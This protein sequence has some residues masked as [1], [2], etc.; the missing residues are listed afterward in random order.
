MARP[1]KVLVTHN[2]ALRAKH[3]AAGVRAIRAA[4]D[5]LVEAD[6]ARGL[7][8]RWLAVDDKRTARSLGAAAVDDP[9]DHA[10]AK[11]FVDAA[12]AKWAPDYVVLLGSPDVIPMQP[13]RNPLW[14]GDPRRGD[15]DPD[16]PSDLPYASE[17]PAGDDPGAFRGATRVVGRL[18]DGT[19]AS[20]IAQIERLLGVAAGYATRPRAELLPPLAITAADWHGSTSETLRRAVGATDG[21]HSVPTEAPPWPGTETTRLLHLVNCHGG[22]ADWRYYGQRGR[23]HP[24]ALDAG[25]LDGGLREGVIGAAECCYG[26][27]LYDAAE[28]GGRPGFADTYLAAGAY[29]YVA[30]TTTSYGPAN[31]N[32]GA[33]VICRQFLLHVLGGASL[34][35]ALLQARQDYVLAKAALSPVD[36]KTLAQ[37]AL[38]GDPAVHA[39]VRTGEPGPPPG[40]ASR[41]RRLRANGDALE[42]STTRAAAEPTR[43]SAPKRRRVREA[44][45][46]VADADATLTTFEVLDAPDAASGPG[47]RFH[48]L[49][50]RGGTGVR[51]VV[52]REEDGSIGPPTVLEER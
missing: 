42:R 36:L 2:G 27:L 52:A 30:S 15:P 28:A 21:L 47:E 33:D 14:T 45:G 8:S 39:V 18:P 26:G 38:F 34:G 7:R 23:S 51:A 44:L 1:D 3:G 6:R 16:V 24:V 20:D 50:K 10:G 40:I 31:G 4:V 43:V 13:L 48:V 11:A 5:R 46:D 19:G 12:H 37:F 35:R 9:A 22:A 41:R 49:Q 29:G 32:D 17:A 25:E